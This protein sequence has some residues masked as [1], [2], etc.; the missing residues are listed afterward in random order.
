[1]APYRAITTAAAKAPSAQTP[2]LILPL[3]P[4]AAPVAFAAVAAVL[5]GIP[6]EVLNGAILVPI[7]PPLD[8]PPVPFGIPVAL[9]PPALTA[10]DVF[11]GYVALLV[12]ATCGTVDSPDVK[13]KGA[14]VDPAEAVVLGTGLGIEDWNEEEGG[15][16]ALACGVLRAKEVGTA[17]G[18]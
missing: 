12:A 13:S 17:V 18:A 11:I 10:M 6:G 15:L 8:A 3:H 5:D 14:A 2:Q 9:T 16:M 4:T 1:M 7:F